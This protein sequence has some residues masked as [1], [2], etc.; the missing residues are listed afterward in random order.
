MCTKKMMHESVIIDDF[1]RQ[2]I[3]EIC[4]CEEGFIPKFK[5]HTAMSKKCKADLNNVAMFTFS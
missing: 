1:A 2:H 4:G 3:D 5:W